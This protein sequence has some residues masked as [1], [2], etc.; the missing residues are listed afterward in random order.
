MTKLLVATSANAQPPAGSSFR[1]V[2]RSV[3][4][5]G[6]AALS[7]FA[8]DNACAVGTGPSAGES[9]FAKLVD[10]LHAEGIEVIIQ[11]GA[12][13]ALSKTTGSA[14][15]APAVSLL[16]LFML[17]LCSSM[18]QLPLARPA[19]GLLSLELHT[20]APSMFVDR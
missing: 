15:C 11:V 4:L 10:G 19:E 9:E 17:L 6:Q 2:K 14:V 18:A 16:Q 7:F 8:A 1:A 13:A 3:L 20:V 12:L 5:Q